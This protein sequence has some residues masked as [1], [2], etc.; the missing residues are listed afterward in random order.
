MNASGQDAPLFEPTPAR[1]RGRV[2]RGLDAD[3]RQALG[4]DGELPAA[5]VANLR[6]LADRIDQLERALALHPKPYDHVPLAALVRQ[7]DETYER[8]FAGVRSAVDPLTAALADFM[9]ADLGATPETGHPPRPV[10]D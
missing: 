10:S 7:F 3:I 2:R 8:T 4:G 1:R 5:G 9:A 6:V